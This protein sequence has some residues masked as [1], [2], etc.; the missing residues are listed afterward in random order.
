V[1]I[2]PLTLIVRNTLNVK[3]I[4]AAKTNAPQATWATVIE[5]IGFSGCGSLG[6]RIR[7]M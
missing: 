5:I 4:V 7:V 2:F 6:D 1:L 3:T